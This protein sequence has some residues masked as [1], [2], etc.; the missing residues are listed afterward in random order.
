[1]KNMATPKFYCVKYDT[2]YYMTPEGG[3]TPHFLHAALV[4]SDY[5]AP[6]GSKVIE[7]PAFSDWVEDVRFSVLEIPLD[8][9]KD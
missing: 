2:G 5:P 8:S 7:C 1:M 4:P 6:K 3:H 9:D